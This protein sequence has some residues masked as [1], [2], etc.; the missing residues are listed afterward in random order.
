METFGQNSI[1]FQKLSWCTTFEPSFMFLAYPNPE[2]LG[3]GK[4]FA[5]PKNHG[6]SRFT[7][8]LFFIAFLI[9]P[10]LVK[11][12]GTQKKNNKGEN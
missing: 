10:I 3:A 2:I 11:N 6:P 12:F 4:T 9:F 7:I 5:D 1:F 8:V